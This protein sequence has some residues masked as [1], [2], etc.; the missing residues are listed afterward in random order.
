VEGDRVVGFYEK[1]REAG[2][3]NGGFLVFEREAVEYMSEEA[4]CSLENGVLQQ[5]A[6]DGQ[7]AVHEHIGWW[8]AVD[9]PK[10]YVQ[11]K[12]LWREASGRWPEHLR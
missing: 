12:S 3:V 9:T 1:E 11:L 10:D 8:Q 7:L 5:L 2:L 4:T 6:A